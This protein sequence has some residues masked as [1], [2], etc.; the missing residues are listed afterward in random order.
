MKLKNFLTSFCIW[1]F[2]FC[3]CFAKVELEQQDNPSFEVNNPV[4]K[5]EFKQQ[6]NQPDFEIKPTEDLA[7]TDKQ[8]QE[9]LEKRAKN[10][11][12]NFNH[13]FSKYFPKVFSVRER[14]FS[15]MT[16]EDIAKGIK[17]IVEMISFKPWDYVDQLFKQVTK[18]LCEHEKKVWKDAG[19]DLKALPAKFNNKLVKK[20][21]K[22]GGGFWEFIV[23]QLCFYNE[24]IEFAQVDLDTKTV[25]L[26]KR[27][28]SWD[29]FSDFKSF[30]CDDIE[31]S[32]SLKD[33]WLKNGVT[34]Y[35]D[36]Y[37]L[38]FL[39]FKNLFL[40]AIWNKDYDLSTR[41]FYDLRAIMNKLNNSIYESK[42]QEDMKIYKELSE[43]LKQKQKTDEAE[44]G[45]YGK[46]FDEWVD[47]YCDDV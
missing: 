8:F 37:N 14:F 36:F 44:S 42:R 24:F 19:Y 4:E 5:V 3:N 47:Y 16:P 21:L 1:L 10:S 38:F 2:I 28:N 15:K 27:E 41:Y 22:K 30:E 6:Q 20:W 40:D 39:K 11:K 26:K 29:I 35:C 17:E 7:L 23:D 12:E 45:G 32:E 34:I 9:W 43:L 18:V 31:G 46:Y 33:Y 13:Y 25:F